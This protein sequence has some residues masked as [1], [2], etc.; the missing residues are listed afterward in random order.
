[1]KALGVKART[2]LA[3]VG[4]AAV[5]CVT[6]TIAT[7]QW[8]ADH[9]R[10][11]QSRLL[12]QSASQDMDWLFTVLEVDPEARTF[13]DLV[14]AGWAS[15]PLGWDSGSEA[16]VVPLESQA[17]PLPTHAAQQW[18]F[19]NFSEPLSQRHPECLEPQRWSEIA[20]QSYLGN[21]GHIWTESCGPYLL[22][23][24]FAQP[25]DSHG[26]LLKPWLIIRALYLPDA[27]DP[28]PALRT[29][30]L[31]LS[32]GVIVLALLLA[33]LVAAAVVRPV[34]RAGAMANAVAGGDL[35]VRIPVRGDDDV[36]AMSLAVNAMADRL[37]AQITD[38]E[39]ANEA[40]R[41]FV[42]DVAHELRTPTTALLASAEALDDPQSRD[43]AAALVTPQ[44]RRLAALTE[45][46][47]EISRMDAGRAELVM[48]RIDLADLITE[49]IVDSGA[50]DLIS[51]TGPSQLFLTTDPARLRV[52]LRNLVTNALQHGEPPV[53]VTTASDTRQVTVAVH[54]GGDGVPL[55]LRERVFD[56]FVRGDESR[57]GTSSGLGLAI[58]AENA[59]LLGGGLSLEP[60]GATFTLR[61]P[62]M[63]G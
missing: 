39:Q 32:A 46:L 27:D 6:I 56:R 57:H 48:S 34:T 43:E 38:L 55:E 44:L 51:Y 31:V 63:P 23:Y 21:G 52:V 22:A 13:E 59:R 19:V 1:M 16:I 49:V 36:A 28:V 62:T 18:G 17:A 30:L 20:D 10:Q 40:Q 37:T 47:L 26:V 53:I 24:A 9:D 8:A 14:E 7:T 42:S 4:T 25:A 50:P 5:A 35:S 15:R 54:D 58:A 45:D 11:N 29:T 12:T 3:V 33:G 61:L 2:M 41:Q 60:D